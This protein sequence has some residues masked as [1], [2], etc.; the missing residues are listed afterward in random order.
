MYKSPR[1]SPQLSSVSHK[2]RTKEQRLELDETGNIGDYSLARVSETQNE[3]STLKQALP[4]TDLNRNRERFRPI[5][6]FRPIVINPNL[7]FA[8]KFEH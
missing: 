6:R 4:T 8:T 3:R 5:S 2:H 1:G 7:L